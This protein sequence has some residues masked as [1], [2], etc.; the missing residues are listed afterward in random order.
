MRLALADALRLRRVQRMD[1]RTT[2]V[3]PLIKHPSRQRQHAVERDLLE[4]VDIA[5]K[6]GGCRESRDRDRL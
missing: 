3:L 2:L 1:L 5:F 4:Q 6:L